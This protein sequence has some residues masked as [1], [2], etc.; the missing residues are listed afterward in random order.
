MLK[1]DCVLLS[2]EIPVLSIIWAIK[3]KFEINKSIAFDK[4][5]QI[6]IIVYSSER[7]LKIRLYLLNCVQFNLL[8]YKVDRFFPICFTRCSLADSSSIL[9]IFFFLIYYVKTPNLNVMKT[10]NESCTYLI[11]TNNINCSTV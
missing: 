1:I 6:F 11:G 3:L 10:G 4:E 2:I 5:K 9:K 7:N 8:F